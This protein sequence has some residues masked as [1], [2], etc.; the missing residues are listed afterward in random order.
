MP[1]D[2]QPLENS[3]SNVNSQPDMAQQP[4]ANAPQAVQEATTFDPVGKATAATAGVANAAAT[5][6]EA[7]IDAALW[8]TDKLGITNPKVSAQAKQM[9]NRDITANLRSGVEGAPNDAFTQA[10]NKYPVTGA[11]AKYGAGTG[12]ALAATPGQVLPQAAGKAANF[13][14]STGINALEGAGLSGQDSG[15]QDVGAA[16]GAGGTA[17]GSLASVGVNKAITS[18]YSAG[19]KIKNFLK[20]INEQLLADGALTVPEQ[21]LKAESTY[22][23]SILHQNNSNYSMVKNI[24]GSIDGSLVT[25]KASNMLQGADGKIDTSLFSSPQLNVIKS[26]QEDAK[27]L[28]NMEDAINLRQYIASN[29][30]LF[31]GKGVSSSVMDQFSNLKSTLDA[32]IGTK[33]TEAGLGDAFKKANE[34]NEFY[35]Q[36]LRDS[37]ATDRLKIMTQQAKR[38]DIISNLKPGQPVPPENPEYTQAIKQIFPVN[39]T[40]QK[41]KELISRMGADG[42]AGNKIMQNYFIKQTFDEISSNPENFNKNNA[43][44]KVNQIVNKYKDVLSK[45]T[46]NTLSG[47]ANVLKEAGA[48]AEKSGLK[49]DSYVM[50]YAGAIIGG[51]IGGAFGG[52]P[53]AAIGS[54]AGIAAG[55]AVA[56][57]IGKPIKGL[58]DSQKGQELLQYIAKHPTAAKK[59]F[60]G[61]ALGID[62]NF[63]N[64]DQPESSIDFQEINN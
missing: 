52:G 25:K 28:N 34:F 4:V 63:I 48:T 10:T 47:A 7:G 14:A 31:Q 59:L 6:L 41:V 33:A 19:T 1:I 27:K 30:S 38:N 64:Q 43:L 24:P 9:A 32:Q 44:I 18:M 62:S 22:T 35:V 60:Q 15:N 55:P 61:S 56:K 21:A 17:L 42:T 39:P 5:G 53:G 12:L 36:P 3:S 46:L 57:L 16:I 8:A 54:M 2:F 37:N 50:H 23:A 58:L 13:L 40:P 51:G 11:I 45:D 49:S 26:I 20:P 29:K